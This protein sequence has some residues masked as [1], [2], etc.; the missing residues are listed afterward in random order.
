[1]RASKVERPASVAM[2]FKA[3]ASVGNRYDITAAEAPDAQAWPEG[4]PGCCGMAKTGVIVGS[5]C[6]G[7]IPRNVDL[8]A[9]HAIGASCCATVSNAEARDA[10]GAAPA[11]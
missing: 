8:A 11:G 9:Q 5:A 7:R 3:V 6:G 2:P 1:M 10:P 4:Y